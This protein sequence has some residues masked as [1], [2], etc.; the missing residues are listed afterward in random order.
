[1]SVY[2]SNSDVNN[3]YMYF[4][5]SGDPSVPGNI[6]QIE[7]EKNF[8]QTVEFLFVTEGWQEVTVN[9]KVLTVEE[10][11][12]LFV[13]TLSTHVYGKGCDAKG[14]VLLL[15]EWYL[16]FFRR[17]YDEKTLPTLMKDKAANEAILEYVRFWH[18]NQG[19]TEYEKFNKAN[20]L[21]AMLTKVYPPQYNVTEKGDELA[22][23]ILMYI[24]DHYREDITLEQIAGEFGYVKQYCS[25]VFNKVLKESFRSY[26]NK[27]RVRKFAEIWNERKTGK[28]STIMSVAFYC[29]FG[30]MATFYRSY[31]EEFGCLP[32]KKD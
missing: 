1:M 27:V 13:E 15:G 18:K 24:N 5:R 10:G 31:K 30:S 23:K 4:V 14:Y 26:L 25:M 17:Q 7:C 9:G 16:Q 11:D 22:V 32:K 28:N 3:K 8:H 21:L 6:H 2:E 29:G 19:G 20:V 12:I